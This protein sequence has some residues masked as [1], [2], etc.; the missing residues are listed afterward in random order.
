[1][2]ILVW[3]AAEMETPAHALRQRIRDRTHR[4]L[5]TGHARGFV[6]ANLVVVPACYRDDLLGFCEANA[7]AC[8]VLGVSEVGDP[9]LPALGHDIDV[10]TDLPGYRIYRQGCLSDVCDDIRGHWGDDLVAVAIG[11]WFSMEEALL[12]AGVRLRHV[13]LGIQGPMFR[14]SLAT[15]PHGALHGPVVVSMRPFQRHDVARVR[16]V[17][18][19]FPRVHGAPIHEGDAS[20]LGIAEISLPDFGERLLP[21]E[22]EVGLF[23]GCGLTATCALQNLG[24][25]FMTHAPGK[26]LVCDVLNQSLSEPLQTS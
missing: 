8:P 12:E 20:A 4:G 18:G 5:T 23:W 15:R 6:Q 24:I 2:T 10:R 1:M 16:E 9:S 3:G 26:M 22:S 17:T 19:R 21:L 7:A 13:E 25:D 11:C 14:S